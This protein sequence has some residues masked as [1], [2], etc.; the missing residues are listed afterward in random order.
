MQL[1]SRFCLSALVGA[2]AGL[3][4][5]L[6][7]GSMLPHFRYSYEVLYALV[8]AVSI[9]AGGY[10]APLSRRRLIAAIL[11]VVG[12]VAL[13]VLDFRGEPLSFLVGACLAYAFHWFTRRA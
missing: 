3:F 5:A 11:V 9:L 1:V 13:A 8:G 6:L 12:T 4:T 7:I 10:A 2:V